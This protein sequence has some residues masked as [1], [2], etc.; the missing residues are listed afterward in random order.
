[1]TRIGTRTRNRNK[2]IIKNKGELIK[3]GYKNVRKLSRKN[4]RLALDKAVKEYGKLTVIRKLS[5]IRALHF[6]KDRE[7]SDKFYNDL[8]YVQSK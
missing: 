2:I 8:K 4:R 3:H 5:A 1:M 6:N 7:L